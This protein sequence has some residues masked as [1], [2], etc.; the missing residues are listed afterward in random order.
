MKF[1]ICFVLKAYQYSMMNPQMYQHTLLQQQQQEQYMR[2][3]LPGGE[4]IY[5]LISLNYPKWA[6]ARTYIL[7]LILKPLVRLQ[8]VA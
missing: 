6:H 7:T 8:I 4:I 2:N 3:F 1:L 5:Y